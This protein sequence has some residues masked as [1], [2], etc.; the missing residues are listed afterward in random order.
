[1]RK[2]PKILKTKQEILRLVLTNEKI[3]KH[4]REKVYVLSYKKGFFF[5]ND[6]EYKYT[7][8]YYTRNP[9][10]IDYIDIFV[11]NEFF[12][13]TIYA[14]HIHELLSLMKKTKSLIFRRMK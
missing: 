11:L 2:K 4:N 3:F 8:Q 12:Y 10:E 14:K 1:M 6:I 9:K 13:K 7:V 5:V